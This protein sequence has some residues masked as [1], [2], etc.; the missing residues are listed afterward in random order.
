MEVLWAADADLNEALAAWCAARIGL[1]RGLARPVRMMGVF[2]GGHLLGAAAFH[3]F[4][5]DAGVMEISA[6]AS[7]P[8]W[9]SRPVLWEMF[10]YVFDRAGCQTCVLRVS[11]RNA[12]LHRILT[13]YGFDHVTVP[14]LRGRDED[15]RIFWL[16]D[17][18]W[19]RNGFHREHR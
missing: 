14:R 6:A 4:D 13:A 12:R 2:D 15:E 19:R 9:L 16:H 10:S 8:R 17:E 7:S 1:A 3:N 18:V 11:A 5:P